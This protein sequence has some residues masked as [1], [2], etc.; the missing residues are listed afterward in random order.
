MIVELKITR[1]AA[2]GL[3]DRLPV[4]VAFRSCVVLDPK[5]LCLGEFNLAN[6][7]R[8][9]Y[10]KEKGPGKIYTRKRNENQKM[11][12]HRFSNSNSNRGFS[13]L[14]V[15]LSIAILGGSIAIIGQGFHHGARSVRV[16][17]MIGEGNRLADSKLSEI[18][19]GATELQSVSQEPFGD[20][21]NWVYSIVAE[22]ASFPGILAV[23]VTVEN[24]QS[25]PPI[26]VS[27]GRLIPDPNH[28]TTGG[29]HP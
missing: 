3:S 28:V 22:Q 5:W 6:A 21:P 11:P 26:Q 23:S 10:N 14:E 20:N 29:E 25:R 16:A 17:R 1:E 18:A 15:I 13:L 2:R 7:S 8:R 19:A 12:R 27:L 9:C 24:R 4:V